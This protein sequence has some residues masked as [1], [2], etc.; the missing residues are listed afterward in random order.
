MVSAASQAARYLS[1]AARD[2]QVVVSFC[3]VLHPGPLKKEK[4]ERRCIEKPHPG[5]LTHPC[6]SAGA[7]IPHWKRPNSS[8]A[9]RSK[10]PA[11]RSLCLIRAGARDEGRGPLREG[12]TCG[13]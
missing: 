9:R 1:R 8:V 6:V 10:N 4:P 13:S 3:G 7:K 2:V 5:V 12:T 11:A